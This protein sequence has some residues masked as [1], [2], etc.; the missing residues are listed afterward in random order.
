MDM[1][2][3]DI[4]DN[5]KEATKK[6]DTIIFSQYDLSYTLLDFKV[7]SVKNDTAIIEIR[8]E[9]K[10]IKGP[11]FRDNIITAVHTLK[12]RPNGWK[13]ADTQIKKTEFL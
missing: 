9:T 7:I 8:Q 5:L 4:D 3:M 6:I 2:L 10:K 11:A 13:I 1:A 12:K